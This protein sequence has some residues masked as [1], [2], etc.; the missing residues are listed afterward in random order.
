MKSLKTTMMSAFLAAGLLASAGPATGQDDRVRDYGRLRG[1]RGAVQIFRIDVPSGAERLT[2]RTAGGEGDAD[3]FVNRGDD[4]D[5]DTPYQSLSDDN[6][7][8][9]DVPDPRG[10]TWTVAL[11]AYRDFSDLRLRTEVYMN[12]P[13][14]DGGKYDDGHDSRRLANGETIRGL[15]GERGSRLVYRIELPERV[16]TL[17]IATSGGSGDLDLFVRRGEEPTSR[18]HDYRSTDKDSAESVVIR[19]PEAGTWYV[20]LYGY[21]DYRDVDLS[22]RWDGGVDPGPPV[23]HRGLELLYPDR[24]TVWRTGESYTIRWR[25]DRAVRRVRIEFSLDGGRSWQTGELPNSID[26]QRGQYRIRVPR[27]RRYLGDDAM[28]RILDV[29]RPRRR[30]V[31]GR[32]EIRLGRPG[33]DDD[34]DDRADRYEPDNSSRRPSRLGM[35]QTQVHTLTEDDE[36]W[37]QVNSPERR[38]H[39]L[40]RFEDVTEPLRIEIIYRKY[41][42]PEKPWENINVGR[43]TKN[44]VLNA[45][46]PKIEYWKF[47]IRAADDDEEGRYRMTLVGQTRARRD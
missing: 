2:V 5:P 27:E 25:A 41:G 20:L 1:R 23:G 18:E 42:D 16:D 47:R 29:D 13:K 24:R 36:D 45:T 19:R 28:I 38:D 17:K 30:S 32:F 8:R 35:G 10:G 15:S 9:I 22:A 6:D 11:R 43:G 46:D 21:R 14:A 7:E 26:G 40:I 34:D 31:S 3:L 39:Y 44:Y 4:F 12:D 37:V 33:D